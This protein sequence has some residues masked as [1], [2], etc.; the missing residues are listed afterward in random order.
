MFILLIKYLAK[1]VL[2]H[3]TIK[4]TEDMMQY[5]DTSAIKYITVVTHEEQARVPTARCV[6]CT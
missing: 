5:I 1:P 2:T 4:P 3:M 6:N